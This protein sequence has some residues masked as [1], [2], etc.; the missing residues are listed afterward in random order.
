MLADFFTKPLQGS[1]FRKFRDAIVAIKPIESL[2]NLAIFRP[3]ERVGEVQ[4]ETPV[5]SNYVQNVVGVIRST[6]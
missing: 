2:S 1:L 4:A 5:E 3:E 6:G